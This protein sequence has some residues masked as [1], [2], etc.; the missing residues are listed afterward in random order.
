MSLRDRLLNRPRPFDTYPLRIDDDTE[1]RKDLERARTLLRL[2][3]FQGESANEE[4]VRSVTADLAKAEAEMAAC[5]EQVV[6]RAMRPGDFEKL[7]GKHKPREGTEDR[8]WNLSTFPRACLMGCV[9]SDLTLE[10]WDQVW[11]EVLSDGEQGELC[12]AA[13]KVNVRVPDSTLPKGW[14]QTQA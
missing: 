7:I 10:D 2:L 6:L 5:Y 4:A 14:T 13:I 3:Q 8:T 1:A 11:E 12:T 9:E